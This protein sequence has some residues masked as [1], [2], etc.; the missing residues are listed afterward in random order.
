MNNTS[1]LPPIEADIKMIEQEM[2]RLVAEITGRGHG[3]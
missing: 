3:M 2:L 1:P